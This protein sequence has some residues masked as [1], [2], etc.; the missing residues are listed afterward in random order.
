MKFGLLGPMLVHDG[1]QDI[2]IPAA[3]QRVLLAAMLVRAGR[4]V[5]AGELAEMVWDGLP[6]PGA[7]TTLRTY[8]KRLR[9][10]LGPRAGARVVTRY[11]G[12]LLAAGKNEVDLLRFTGLCREGGDAVRDGSW[13]RA[14]ALLGEALGLWRGAAMADVPCSTLQRDESSRLEQLRL[15]AAEWRIEA[16]LHLGWDSELLPELHSL[17]AEYPLRERFHAQLM[18]ALYRCGRQG[19]ALAAYRHARQVLVKE[20]GAEPGI[21]LRELHQRILVADAGLLDGPQAGRLHLAAPPRQLPAA[22]GLFTGR[23]Q[24]LN[25]LTARLLPGGRQPNSVVLL[26]LGGTAGV[27]KTALALRW[28]HEVAHRFPDGQLFANLR[29]YDC[30]DPADPAEVLAGLLRALEVPGHDIPAELEARAARYRSLLAGRRMLVLLDNA[31][32]AEQVRPLLPG[33]AG[34]LAVITSRNALTGLVVRDGAHRVDVE[35]LTVDESAEL[36]CALIGPRAQADL[37]G[38]RMLAE[39]CSR[40]PLALRLAAELM[41]LRPGVGIADLA[42]ELAD[43]GQRLHLL[44]AGDDDPRT[45]LRTVFSWSYRRLSADQAAAFRLLGL[46]PDADFDLPAIAALTGLPPAR[47]RAVTEALH[48][49]YLIQRPSADRYQMLGLLKAYAAEQAHELDDAATRQAALTRL[50]DHYAAVAC[51]ARY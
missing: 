22:P 26:L 36:L 20:L 25:A 6:P 46:Y 19:E 21:E 47:A 34:S 45:A 7:P 3:R 50:R 39:R 40:L 10:V 27:G 18:L 38:R 8:V 17:A 51:P 14:S 44:D 16:G 4:V 48:R 13:A 35:V 1:D 11:P 30:G 42:S 29:G 31:S 28:A 5:P 41:S 9:Q 12:Y 37:S 23:V 33:T 43:R 32:S 24:E 2:T 15:Q 49:A